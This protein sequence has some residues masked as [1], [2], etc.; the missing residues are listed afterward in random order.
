MNADVCEI[1]TDVDGVYSADP[2]IVPECQKNGR[3]DLREMLGVLLLLG[4]R[5]CV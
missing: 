5:Y 4:Q 2:R 3:S 1:Y